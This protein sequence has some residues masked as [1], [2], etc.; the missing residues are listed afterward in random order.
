M[1][2]IFLNDKVAL[3]PVFCRQLVI[4]K[5]SEKVQSIRF[6]DLIQYKLLKK[7]KAFLKKKATKR[8]IPSINTSQSPRVINAYFNIYSPGQLA[9]SAI[10][11]Y[12][13]PSAFNFFPDRSLQRLDL[14]AVT[15]WS[16][17]AC[18]TASR[19]SR[20]ISYLKAKKS[21]I[22]SDKEDMEYLFSR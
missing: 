19:P 1:K 8:S 7:R 18:R 5:S 14:K 3:Y 22:E 2:S 16:C 13:F 9:S 17:L 12:S 11:I 10:R 6:L 21:T 20:T 4:P 15:A